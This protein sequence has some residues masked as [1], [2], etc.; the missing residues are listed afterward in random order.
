[1]SQALTN[2]LIMPNN[3]H[4]ICIVYKQDNIQHCVC[5][6]GKDA[7]PTFSEMMFWCRNIAF[8]VWNQLAEVLYHIT[9]RKYVLCT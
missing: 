5:L 1:M 9:S 6:K 3:M 7:M 2:A 8:N 4:F